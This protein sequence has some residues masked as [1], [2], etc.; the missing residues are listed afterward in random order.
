MHDRD[1]GRL[2]RIGLLTPQANPT[3][4]PEMRL[5]LPAGVTLLTGRCTSAAAEPGERFLEYLRRLDRTLDGFD[6]PGVGTI[7]EGSLYYFA[8]H[9]SQSKDAKAQMMATPLDAGSD[10]QPP[11]LQQFEDALRQAT[12]QAGKQ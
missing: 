7:R 4:E 11:D 6:T 10:V 3:A 9:G 8:N 5:L 2:G 1:Y 12:E